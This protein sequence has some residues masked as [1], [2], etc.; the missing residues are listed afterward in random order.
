MA[1]ISDECMGMC[2][3]ARGIRPYARERLRVRALRMRFCRN[4]RHGTHGTVR[5][6]ASR[7]TLRRSHARQVCIE[8]RPHRCQRDKVSFMAD[9][10]VPIWQ[11]RMA[12]RFPAR[13]IARA[14]SGENF[15]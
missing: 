10:E 2:K 7:S 3:R 5:A 8:G 4:C 9:V 11:I 13:E 1:E 6:Y 12:V 15:R 14:R